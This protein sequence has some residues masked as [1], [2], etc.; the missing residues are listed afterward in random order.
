MQTIR[1]ISFDLDDTLWECEPVIRRAE[2]SLL[3]WLH[4]RC[5]HLAQNYDMDAFMARKDAFMRANPQLHGDVS[6]MRLALL[7]DLLGECGQHAALVQ[8]AYA[9]FY[10]MR[11]EVQLYEDALP[12]LERLR[13]RY[14][15]AALTNGNADLQ[16]IGIAPLF[17]RIFYASL[18]CPAKPDAHMF[19]ETCRDFGI[20]AHELLH[21][22]DNPYTDV[23]GARRAGARTV[24]IKRAEMQ[25]PAELAPAD[26]EI[27][28]LN[29]LLGVLGM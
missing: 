27:S 28:D 2:M 23:E 11:S 14:P 12:A 6:R 16:R 26:V 20:S 7:E 1:A 13:E 19:A 22:G 5:D 10:T 17:Q 21:V 29:E 3:R 25:W 4:E 9:H 15:L 24:W 18:E 8:E